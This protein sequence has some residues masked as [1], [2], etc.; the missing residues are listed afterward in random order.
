MATLDKKEVIGLLSFCFRHECTDFCQ[1]Y[2]TSMKE[3]GKNPETDAIDQWTPKDA[4]DCA[5]KAIRK[6]DRKPRVL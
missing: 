4:M 5:M 6:S 1:L 2:I 3:L